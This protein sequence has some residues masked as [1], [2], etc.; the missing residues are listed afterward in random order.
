VALNG[1]LGSGKTCLVKGIAKG[2]GID[3]NITSPTYT[4][5][6]EYQGMNHIDAYRLSGEKDFEDIGGM[7]IIN[8]DNIS[9]IEWGERISK[10]LPH[11][12]VVISFEITGPDSRLIMIEGLESL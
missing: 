5:I 10:C 2:L 11:D 6:N 9:V 4:I 8:S 7:D 12:A 3:E 1:E